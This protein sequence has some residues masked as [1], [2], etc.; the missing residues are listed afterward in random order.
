MALFVFLLPTQLAYHF[1][2]QFAYVYGL[3][4]DYLS[5][6]IYLTDILFLP[7]IF[8]IRGRISRKILWFVLLAGI[9]IFFAR[10]PILSAFK[11]LTVFK[12][13]LVGF[14]FY[15]CKYGKVIRVS[16]VASAVFFALVGLG[17]FV[18][19]GTLGG[20]LYWL[21]ERNFN[22]SMPGIALV[23]IGGKDFLRAYSTFSHPNSFA[24]FIV[25]AVVAAYA[26][27]TKRKL[28][29]GLCLVGVLILTF[30]LGATGGIFLAVILI[31]LNKKRLSYLPVTLILLSFLFAFLPA[32][33]FPDRESLQTRLN[34]AASSIGQLADTPLVGVGLN[35]SIA[36]SEKLQPVHNVFLLVGAETGLIGLLSV[37]VLLTVLIAKITNRYYLLAWFFVLFT[38]TVDHY[39]FTLQQNQLLLSLLA[40]LALN[41]KLNKKNDQ[42]FL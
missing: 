27:G 24:G 21:G 38:M 7:L 30:S 6:A 41:K 14:Y 3:R 42:N 5:P 19:K 13:M 2:P 29:P 4:V 17:Q 39:W 23:K 35:N 9:N 18:N 11:W 16:L 10:N 28:L 34:L 36:H 8:F 37:F 15:G 31:W 32:K 1:W 40:G 25:A 12:L 22:V 33:Y 26:L 20:L